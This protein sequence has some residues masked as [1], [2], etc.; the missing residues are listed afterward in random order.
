MAIISYNTVL[1]TNTSEVMNFYFVF[2]IFNTRYI[3]QLLI[4]SKEFIHPSLQV[5]GD[6]TLPFLDVLVESKDV[7]FLHQYLS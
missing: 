3:S 2:S 5:E 4:F 1:Q 7:F 6:E